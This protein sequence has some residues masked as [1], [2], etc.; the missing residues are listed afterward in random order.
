MSGT[1]TH[2][3]ARAQDDKA[4]QGATEKL[5]K[6]LLLQKKKVLSKKNQ[7]MWRHIPWSRWKLNECESV[8]GD[9]ACCIRRPRFVIFIWAVSGIASSITH[10]IHCLLQH[11][12]STQEGT[13]SDFRCLWICHLSKDAMHCGIFLHKIWYGIWGYTNTWEKDLAI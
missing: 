10:L 13:V 4:E 3:V 7:Q 11:I 8:I 6:Q 2:T 12:V 5:S 1:Q 9:D